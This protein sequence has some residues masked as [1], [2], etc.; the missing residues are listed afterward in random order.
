MEK[1]GGRKLGSENKVTRATKGL[2]S[3]VIEN[4]L[5]TIQEDLEKLSPRDRIN[6]IIQLMKFIV[7]TLKS[8]DV[9]GDEQKSG[10]VSPVLIQF[11]KNEDSN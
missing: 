2:I 5:V 10:L 6:A 3:N 4:N 7:P 8:V 9:S 1:F 11:V